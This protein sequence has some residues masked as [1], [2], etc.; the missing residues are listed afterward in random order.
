[1]ELT[2][3]HTAGPCAYSDRLQ[4]SVLNGMPST[5]LSTQDS[6]NYV[7]EKTERLYEPEII[8]ITKG[9]SFFIV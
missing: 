8:D 1:M 4:N 7:E 6:G 3:T 9:F 5:T 2:Q